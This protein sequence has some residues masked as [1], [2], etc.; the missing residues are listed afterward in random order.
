MNK[1]SEP[2]EDSW[3]EASATP[4]KSVWSSRLSWALF[5]VFVA[6]YATIRYW[7]VVKPVPDFDSLKIISADN[8]KATTKRT[9]RL[10]WHAVYFEDK[11][12]NRYETLYVG[13]RDVRAIDGR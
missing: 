1:E 3:E 7:D 5:I 11:E 2:V 9:F 10:F 4:E 12:G 13:P 6:S 8:L